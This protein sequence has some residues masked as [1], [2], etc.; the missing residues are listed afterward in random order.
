MSLRAIVGAVRS[1]PDYVHRTLPRTERSRRAVSPR[2]CSARRSCGGFY[3][4]HV[5]MGIEQIHGYRSRCP[6]R[7]E[8]THGAK[9]AAFGKFRMPLP[10]TVRRSG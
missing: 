9:R 5:V 10:A 1:Q 6:A 7:W 3:D 2:S 8:Q 4:V